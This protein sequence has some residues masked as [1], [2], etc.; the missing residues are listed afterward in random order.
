MKPETAAALYDYENICKKP[1][2][3]T[4]KQLKKLEEELKGCIVPKE[5]IIIECLSAA[6]IYVDKGY[7]TSIYGG[8]F[9]VT[10]EIMDDEYT[11]DMDRG[12]LITGS[13]KELS[14]TH[15]NALNNGFI[16]NYCDS[17]HIL[18]AMSEWEGVT[19]LEEDEEGN[20]C[21]VTKK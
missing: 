14:Y 4:P 21:L 3:H 10:D 18:Y 2:T 19:Y 6:K 5:W 15:F 7:R 17:P 20:L 16:Y 11:L 13:G 12:V 1:Y 8:K 9:R